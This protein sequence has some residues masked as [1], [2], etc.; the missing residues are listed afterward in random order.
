MGY[1]NALSEDYFRRIGHP[2]DG[3]MDAAWQFQ[4]TLLRDMLQ[5]LEV[6]LDDEGVDRPTGERVIRSL[7]YGSPLP[8]E[9]ER[10]MREERRMIELLEHVPSSVV[11]PYG[12]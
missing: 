5:R 11:Y 9:A 8:A 10:R 2:G 12:P 1:A 6:I 3:A 4:H 7:L